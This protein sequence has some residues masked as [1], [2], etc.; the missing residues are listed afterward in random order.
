MPE[1]TEPPKMPKLPPVVER[2][3][4]D[5]L[6]VWLH[7]N[8]KTAATEAGSLMFWRDGMLGHLR[9]LADGEMIDPRIK[10]LKREFKQSAEPVALA[11]QKLKDVRNKLAG[12]P[13]A[14]QIDVIMD[15]M[16]FG[17]NT[18]RENI[19]LLFNYAK[20]RK[21]PEGDDAVR[22]QARWLCNAID[23]LNAEIEK[24]YRMAHS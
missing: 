14:R 2:M 24:L 3:L 17:K 21:G 5:I 7:R 4:S 8:E 9:E 13:L 15:D 10:L 22:G 6:D 20:D 18:V 11:L 23:T 1:Q 12:H 16:R 19:E